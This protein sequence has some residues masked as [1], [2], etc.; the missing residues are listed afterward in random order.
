MGPAL[1]PGQY[2]VGRMLTSA[3]SSSLLPVAGGA[4]GFASDNG[5]SGCSC[6]PGLPSPALL[7]S[8]PTIPHHIT[9]LSSSGLTTPSGVTSTCPTVP[10]SPSSHYPGLPSLITM[11]SP[12]S[13]QAFLNHTGG[14]FPGH[15][16][17]VMLS[18]TSSFILQVAGSMPKP[19][20]ATTKA[21]AHPQA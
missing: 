21:Q 2:T 6:Y 18:Q 16:L 4:L 7:S 9:P 17:H 8:V 10:D 3:R 5:R 20:K 13:Y 1:S 15:P 19:S 11:S 14:V 12:I